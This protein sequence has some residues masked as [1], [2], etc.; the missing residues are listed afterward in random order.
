[1]PTPAL[2][3]VTSISLLAA[4]QPV[5]DP[6]RYCEAPARRTRKR[7]LEARPRVVPRPPCTR[8]HHGGS[9]RRLLIPALLAGVSLSALVSLFCLFSV[10]A[11]WD[12]VS[13]AAPGALVEGL[14]HVKRAYSMRVAA[15]R[16][17]VPAVYLIDIFIG[18][19]VVLMLG[20]MLSAWCC[21][22]APCP[23]LRCRSIVRQPLCC[24]CYLCTCCGGLAC[25]ECIGCGPCAEAVDQI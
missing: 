13:D 11:G 24:P 12:A 22:G 3:T 18:L 8:H 16:S 10:A 15:E 21:H 4:R 25:L 6:Y 23:S 2:T 7:Q 19:V 5:M 14:F 9:L 17:R 1:M 20:I